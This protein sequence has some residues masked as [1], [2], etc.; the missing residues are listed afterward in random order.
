MEQFVGQLSHDIR[1][2]LNAC[3]LQLTFLGETVTE[4]DAAEDIKRLRATIAGITRQLQ[5]V[6][7]S[8]SGANAHLMDYPAADLLEDLRERF[9]RAHPEQAAEVEWQFKV[10]KETSVNVDPE[11]VMGSCLEILRNALYFTGKNGRITLEISE[12]VDGV[13][14]AFEQPFTAEPDTAPHDWG[15]SPLLSTRRGGY[16]LGLYRARRALAAS[17]CGLAFRRAPER[18]SLTATVTLPVSSASALA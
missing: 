3:E 18:N 16:G 11:L 13:R 4:P 6:R 7:V 12:Q 14:V 8:M 2:G 15:R 9:E 5:A 17:G 10:A 1:N